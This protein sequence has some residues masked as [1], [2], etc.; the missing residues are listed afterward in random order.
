MFLQGC[1]GRLD[2]TRSDRLG[3]SHLLL[4]VGLCLNRYYFLRHANLGRLELRFQLIESFLQ[5]TKILG[6]LRNNLRLQVM[7]LH[8]GRRRLYLIQKFPK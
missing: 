5:I 8:G 2:L 3:L 6:F 7:H 1:S 4:E